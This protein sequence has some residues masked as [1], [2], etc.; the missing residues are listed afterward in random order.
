MTDL[1]PISLDVTVDPPVLSMRIAGEIDMETVVVLRQQL[2]A[3]LV[4][5]CCHISLDLADVS[6]M[7]SSGIQFLLRCRTRAEAGGGR[8]TLTALSPAARR[9]IDLIGLTD[10]LGVQPGLS[11]PSSR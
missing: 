10:H 7:D 11:G 5:G 4:D 9:L 8:L 6:F 1:D 3:G 2:D